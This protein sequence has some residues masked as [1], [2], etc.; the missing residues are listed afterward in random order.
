MNKPII[1]AE[2]DNLIYNTAKAV[3]DFLN[4]EYGV[5]YSE[6]EFYGDRFKSVIKH[7]YESHIVAAI[8]SVGLA[9][10]A[11]KRKGGDELQHLLECNRTI[12][13]SLSRAYKKNT[14][15]EDYDMLGIEEPTVYI[16]T[17][18]N[19]CAKMPTD[20][21]ILVK[22]DVD[23]KRNY[24]LGNE[25]NFYVVNSLQEVVQILNFYIEHPEMIY[26]H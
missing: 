3:T 4:D 10:L 9:G 15:I 18:Y 13:V 16:G 1:I 12:S 25:N 11:Q 14:V 21:R 5:H 23:H 6:L 24:T 17:D 2:V 7:N 8:E 19:T 20:L 22:F 26:Y